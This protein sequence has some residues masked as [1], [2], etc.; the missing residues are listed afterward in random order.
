M[1]CVPTGSDRP[2]SLVGS[3][4][5]SPCPQLAMD[6]GKVSYLQT[7]SANA[8]LSLASGPNN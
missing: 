1:L 4:P 7:L 5:H 6:R 8:D 3:V 2:Y